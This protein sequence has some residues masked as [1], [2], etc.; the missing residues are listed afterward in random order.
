[1]GVVAPGRSAGATS[2][3][4]GGAKLG[5]NPLRCDLRGKAFRSSILDQPFPISSASR[6]A[7]SASNTAYSAS[8]MAA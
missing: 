5:V 4:A 2:V 3:H 6:C 8:S 1:V 7:R